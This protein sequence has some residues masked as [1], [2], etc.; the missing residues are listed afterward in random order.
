M[1]NFTVNFEKYWSKLSKQV[2]LRN[3]NML[4]EKGKF[5]ALFHSFKEYTKHS[6]ILKHIPM[7]TALISYCIIPPLIFSIW[8]SVPAFLFLALDMT[9]FTKRYLSSFSFSR[10]VSNSSC[11]MQQ[12][13]KF[14]LVQTLIFFKTTLRLT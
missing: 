7:K 10:F 13:Y 12:H 8:F 2:F 14:D 11:L 4:S 9:L 6:I 1:I 5:D 3:V